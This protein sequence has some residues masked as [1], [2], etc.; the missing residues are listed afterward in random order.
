MLITT[1]CISQKEK[2]SKKL[3]LP[4]H[5]N[6]SDID[7]N[8]SVPSLSSRQVNH[9]SKPDNEI[10]NTRR[11][12]KAVKHI[13]TS[14]RKLLREAAPVNTQTSLFYQMARLT[15]EH[16][17]S[18]QKETIME[19]VTK[20]INH[21]SNKIGV[22]LPLSGQHQFLGEAI[23]DGL[24]AASN[25]M[26][27]PFEKVF[28]IRDSAGLSTQAKTA[29]ADLIFNHNVSLII[30][31]IT[32][33]E[34]LSLAPYAKG[35]L[36]PMLILNKNQDIITNNRYTFQVFPNSEHLAT[37][38]AYAT[39]YKNVQ[40]VAILKPD[41]GKSDLLIDLY[42]N[43]LNQLGIVTSQVITYTP[44]DYQSMKSA[45]EAISGTNISD[46]IDEYTEL[47]NRAKA[48]AITQKTAFNPKMLVLSPRV[49][50]DAVF[51]PDNFRIVRHF[52][53]LFKYYGI[54]KLPLIGQQ[55]WRSEGLI[56]PW[57]DFLEGSIFI[58]YI[59]NYYQ[60][61]S[62]LRPSGKG[63]EFF[64]PSDKAISIDFSLVGYRSALIGLKI[65]EMPFIKR[66][67]IVDHL[68]RMKGDEHFVST[69]F[70]F[71]K[72]RS[73]FWPTYILSISQSG[74]AIIDQNT[75]LN[76][77]DKRDK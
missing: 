42:K 14:L 66:Y 54:T 73:A 52:V 49:E 21:H 68:Q 19:L 1:G 50:V 44:G 48:E 29:L 63:N 3:V 37:T 43:K 30:G 51:I 22:I 18:K 6:S 8:S 17:H 57:D 32:E 76:V 40:T 13:G 70:I 47:Y 72:Q 5:L 26:K 25:Q 65:V 61:P 7:Y 9:S 10:I 77:A 69:G 46:R 67:H 58:D 62:A 2:R 35:L 36:L 4:I 12:L 38:L 15:P 56:Y 28:V 24:K 23:M 60:L 75:H 41:N 71:N 53:K 64:V 33:T 16:C 20:S 39:R 31:G 74:L 55:E 27:L 59:G 11:C 45:S 34:A